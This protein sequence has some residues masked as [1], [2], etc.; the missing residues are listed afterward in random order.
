MSRPTGT[1]SNSLPAE[2]VEILACVAGCLKTKL[3]REQVTICSDSQMVIVL[4]S[5]LTKLLLVIDCTE[6]LTALS[7]NQVFIVWIPEHSGFTPNEAAEVLARKW[8]G[9]SQ[10]N[11]NPTFLHPWVDIN[12][13]KK[14]GLKD[15][16]GWNEKPVKNTVCQ[17]FWKELL[18]DIF[19][20]QGGAIK[21][22]PKM[23]RQN[24]LYKKYIQGYY[25]A[26]QDTAACLLQL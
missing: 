15:A 14:T 17:I 8:Q 12:S 20:I 11:Q 5:S 25:R 9:P 21:T 7:E 4:E 3:F 18:I 23:W 16:K 19:N 2:V 10:Q 6:K 1:G 13:R 26:C 24:V 22:K